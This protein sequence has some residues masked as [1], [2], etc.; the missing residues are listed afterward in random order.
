VLLPLEQRCTVKVR[1]LIGLRLPAFRFL[2]FFAESVR[3]GRKNNKKR[4]PQHPGN[5][6]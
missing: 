4:L 1:R 2:F 3:K 6:V 5:A